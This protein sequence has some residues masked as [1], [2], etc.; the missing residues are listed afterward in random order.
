[1]SAG[2]GITYTPWPH[3]DYPTWSMP[4]LEA[5]KCVARQGADVFERVH[6]KL[7]EAFFTE[8]RNIGDPNEVVR[9]V[10]EAGVDGDRFLAD[11]R[12]GAGREPVVREYLGAIEEGVRA[13]PTVIVPGT[14]RA[15][16]GL[17]DTEQ[18]RAAVE[19]AAGD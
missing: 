11:Y 15:L 18:Y 16:V 2:D 13:I 5:A 14:G 10:A 17:V 4:A 1:M 7:Y 6:L 8:S 19:E 12:A 3:H 9:V